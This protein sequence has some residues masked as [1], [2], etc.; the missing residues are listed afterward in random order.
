M[1]IANYIIYGKIP[2]GWQ[3]HTDTKLDHCH[4]SQKESCEETDT[5]SEALKNYE[6]PKTGQNEKVQAVITYNNNPD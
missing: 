3:M 4:T 5:M 1:Q 6:W 2:D